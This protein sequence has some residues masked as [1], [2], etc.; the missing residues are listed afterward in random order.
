MNMKVEQVVGKKLYSKYNY[1][2][3]LEGEQGQSSKKTYLCKNCSIH[4]D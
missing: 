3:D 2:A 4:I 1:V